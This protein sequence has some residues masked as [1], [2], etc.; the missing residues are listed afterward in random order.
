MRVFDNMYIK[1]AFIIVNETEYTIINAFESIYLQFI[2][3]NPNTAINALIENHFNL[4]S[5]EISLTS[6]A[7]IEKITYRSNNK[8]PRNTCI[9]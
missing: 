7:F 5:Y 4:I 8:H 6:Y 1:N 2:E 3:N 9:K